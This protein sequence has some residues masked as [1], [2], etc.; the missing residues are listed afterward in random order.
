L[1][2]GDW[3]QQGRTD[4]PTSSGGH[5]GRGLLVQPCHGTGDRPSIIQGKFHGHADRKL[6]K[7]G[8][9]LRRL[10][11]LKPLNDAPIQFELFV[12]RQVGDVE[13][14][15]MRRSISAE[16]LRGGSGPDADQSG[17]SVR[18]PKSP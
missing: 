6:R 17:S 12:F 11:E 7:P 10:D 15:A 13:R 18:L 2:L 14:H 3:A 1:R 9:V 16:P 4:P 8:Q 5:D